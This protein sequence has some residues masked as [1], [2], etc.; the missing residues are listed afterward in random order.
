MMTFLLEALNLPLVCTKNMVDAKQLIEM[1]KLNGATNLSS[2]GDSGA[3]T[4]A[5]NKAAGMLAVIFVT[6]KRDSRS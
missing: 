1:W 2:D 3:I 6:T 5:D 4:R